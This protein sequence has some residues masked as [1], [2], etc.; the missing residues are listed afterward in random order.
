VEPEVSR[1]L[2]GN[3]LFVVCCVFYLSW[4][5]LC[6]RPVDP[7]TGMK[8][9][10]LLIPAA[11]AGLAGV[12]ALIVGES[13]VGSGALFGN[14]FVIPA[15]IVAYV[16]LFS[17]TRY[18][19]DRPATSELFLIVIWGMLAVAE[20]NALVGLGLVGRPAS[21][22]LMAVVAA[23]LIGSLVC[24]VL[25]YRLPA[26]SSYIDGMVPLVMT[27]LFMAGMAVFIIVRHASSQVS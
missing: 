9:G 20:V 8:T 25:Y 6:F 5:V 10:W 4:W 27:A 15:G 24:Y 18:V 3:I 2:V 11:I 26:R 7:I 14:V 23:V 17:I 12:V 16:L 22:V 1:I 21:Y 19:F 13:G